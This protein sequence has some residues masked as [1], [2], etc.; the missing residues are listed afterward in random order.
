MPKL[1]RKNIWKSMVNIILLWLLIY[2]VMAAVKILM[3]EYNNQYTQEDFFLRVQDGTGFF[4]IMV[5]YGC[6][7]LIGPALPDYIFIAPFSL[8]DRKDLI[9]RFF[10]LNMLIDFLCLSILFAA[11]DLVKFIRC[12]NSQILVACL[13]QE[14]VL[15]GILYILSYLKYFRECNVASEIG[16]ILVST[17][18][19]G[20]LA[21]ILDEN[22]EF[23]LQ[24][25]LLFLF[26]VISVILTVIL[27]AYYYVRHFKAM[28]DYYSDYEVSHCPK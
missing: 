13:V 25:E 24:E 22:S 4:M 18:W 11:S 20:M 2:I 3:G 21:G 1:L 19:E 28:I 26:M 8:K 15:F 9:K 5:L 14:I 23:V 16:V 27:V 7:A 6:F 10:T 17:L 12:H